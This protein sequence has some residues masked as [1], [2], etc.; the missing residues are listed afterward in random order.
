LIQYD[1]EDVPAKVRRIAKELRGEWLARHAVHQVAPQYSTVVDSDRNYVRVS[2]SFCK[3]LGYSAEE[4]IGQKYDYVTASN[5][6][7]ILTV[8]NLFNQLGYMHGL[9]MLV[10]RTGTQILVRYEAWLREDSCIESN[11]EL[12]RHLR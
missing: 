4:L 5:T 8:F 3:L 7:D 11:M 12:V 2:D 6:N 10:H 9:W 1:A